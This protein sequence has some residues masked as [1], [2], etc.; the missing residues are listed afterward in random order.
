MTKGS[1]AD[2][3]GT[4]RGGN[5]K[6]STAKSRRNNYASQKDDGDEYVTLTQKQ[7]EELDELLPFS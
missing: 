3:G 5:K 4:G 1:R 2:S 7:L 6:G